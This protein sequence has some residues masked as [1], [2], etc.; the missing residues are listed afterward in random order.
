MK[1]FKYN[2]L[3]KNELFAL[4]LNSYYQD[5]NNFGRKEYEKNFIE[6]DCFE[7]ISLVLNQ[8]YLLKNKNTSIIEFKG[9]F[10][11]R[12]K[13]A[14]I[15]T[16]EFNLKDENRIYKCYEGKF[17]YYLLMTCALF[18]KFFYQEIEDE[19]KNILRLAEFL[20]KN[21]REIKDNPTNSLL[22]DKVLKPF[23][24][25][26]LTVPDM[27]DHMNLLMDELKSHYVFEKEVAIEEVN[28]D[29]EELGTIGLKIMFL[30]ELGVLDFLKGNFNFK[31]N[32]LK[33][34]KVLSV[35]TGIDSLKI[36]A[37][38]HPIYSDFV[39]QKNNPYENHKNV[40]KI[41]AKFVE[42]MLKE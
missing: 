28:I 42:L 27:A 18:Y 15:G 29:E 31:G 10:T 34:S 26:S 17:V 12:K 40:A 2:D 4:I 38:I 7:A 41:K 1:N 25:S 11:Q 5:I 3:I 14:E 39:G 8:F 24:E 19:D 33:L 9:D 37:V 23:K 30:I 35:F 21:S 6:K 13:V 22:V 20:E 32:N 36:N 16:V